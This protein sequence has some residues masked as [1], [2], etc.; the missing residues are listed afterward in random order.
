MRFYPVKNGYGTAVHWNG[1]ISKTLCGR[2]FYGTNTAR[3]DEVATCK[4]CIRAAEKLAQ[5]IASG[6]CHWS[7]QV[8]PQQQAASVQ[9]SCAVPAKPRVL[10]R[11][12]GSKSARLR[13]SRR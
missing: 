8:H 3:H 10:R 7:C 13:N 12:K 1:V 5:H 11:F 2:T 6:P 4:S 9:S